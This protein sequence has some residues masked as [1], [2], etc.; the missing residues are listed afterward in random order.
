MSA[1]LES[2][3]QQEWNSLF[4][5]KYYT[6]KLRSSAIKGKLENSHFRSVCWKVL[7]ECLPEDQQSWIDTTKLQRKHYDE[8]L[9]KF[10]VN[11]RKLEE[12]MDISVNNPLSQS[13]QSPWNQYFQDSELKVTIEQ[14]V[15]RTFPE[16]DFFRSTKVQ[17]LMINILFSYAREYPHVSYKQGMHEL[18]APIIF[19]LHCDQ[20]AYLEVSETDN[21]DLDI[22]IMLNQNYLEHD[23]FFLFCQLMEAVEAWYT[24]AESRYSKCVTLVSSEPFAE[25]LSSPIN[26]LG[27]K[28]K[29]IYKHLLKHHDVELFLHLEQ[30]E[31]TPQIYGIRWLR[32][33]F[34]REFPIHDLLIVWDA[35]FAD[36]ISF[37]LVDYIFVAM[38]IAIRDLLLKNDYA[39]CLCHLMH[40]PNITEVERI[41]SLALHLRDPGMAKPDLCIV[42]ISDVSKAKIAK[43]SKSSFLKSSFSRNVFLSQ[44][45]SASVNKNM[46]ARP[47]SLK[48]TSVI[49]STSDSS[50]E[51]H[52]GI[53]VKCIEKYDSCEIVEPC[54]SGV[55]EES[56]EIFLYAN[57]KGNYNTFPRASIRNVMESKS[58]KVKAFEVSQSFGLVEDKVIPSGSVCK[59]MVP[60]VPTTKNS[61]T[62]HF[63]KKYKNASLK[64]SVTEKDKN[65][66][67]KLLLKEIS[68]LKLMNEYCAKQ[69][70]KH[71]AKLQECMIGQKQLL[72]ED[73][74]FVSLAG[75]KRARDI[76]K[77]TVAFTEDVIDDDHINSY[78][79]HSGSKNLTENNASSPDRRC[80]ENLK[81]V[82]SGDLCERKSSS[83]HFIHQV[84]DSCHKDSDKM[85]S[86]EKNFLQN[87]DN[88]DYISFDFEKLHIKKM[89]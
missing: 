17:E 47:K 41:I 14:D 31:I 48:I 13:N 49:P 2:L 59:E 26:S 57:N 1:E 20:Q 27:V 4:R 61:P 53:K 44:S 62:E 21:L 84:G 50:F 25:G 88:H 23:A 35:I 65:E 40:Y 12:S 74:M 39:S 37:D 75:L 86:C 46:N 82:K 83:E 78:N 16:I 38:L 29:N 73:E 3:Y 87:N 30:M 81:F 68:Q 33:L 18:L 89:S 70:T 71:I 24:M 32:L 66:E 19:V 60:L 58:L 85:P 54:E 80:F 28:L 64:S 42:Q 34:G 9:D 63:V 55:Y 36:G 6:E 45:K 5:T 72:Y 79:P 76:L 77:G 52:S 15:V 67:D 11:P 7:L 8:I 43:E 56:A 10:H 51:N 22:R 69:I